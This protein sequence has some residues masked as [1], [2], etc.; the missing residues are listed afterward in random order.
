MVISVKR[1]MNY[2]NH[3]CILEQTRRMCVHHL[4][5]SQWKLFAKSAWLDTL[6]VRT[7]P[8]IHYL[9]TSS[10]YPLPAY[11]PK[12]CTSF[13][14]CFSL[15]IHKQRY[16]ETL[17]FYLKRACQMKSLKLSDRRLTRFESNFPSQLDLVTWICNRDAKRHLWSWILS[18]QSVFTWFRSL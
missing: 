17:I 16:F 12:Y 6:T 14:R 10:Y 7:S 3:W 9:T 18:S 8:Q 5:I 2:Q 11:F 15:N 4:W 1:T 13:F